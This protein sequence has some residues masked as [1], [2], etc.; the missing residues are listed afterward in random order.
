MPEKKNYVSV[1]KGVNNQKLC[2]LQKSLKLP[3]IIYCFQRATPKWI[4][5]VLKDLCLETQRV[6]SEWLRNDS[7]CF[8]LQRSSKCVVTSWCNGLGLDIQRPDQEDRLQHWEWEMHH[9]SVRILS[10]HCNSERIS[11]SGTQRTWRWWEI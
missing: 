4:Y 6:C 7:L 3:M 8:R 9:A 10:W 5:W 2:N 11:W 1:N